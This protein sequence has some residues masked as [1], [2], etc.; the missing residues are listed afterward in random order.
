MPPVHT[1]TECNR[2]AKHVLG[3]GVSRLVSAPSRCLSF[4]SLGVNQRIRPNVTAV[5]RLQQPPQCRAINEFAFLPCGTVAVTFVEEGVGSGWYTGTH[6]PRRPCRHDHPPRNLVARAPLVPTPV[7]CTNH[8]VGVGS[9]RTNKHSALLEMLLPKHRRDRVRCGQLG[10]RA[11]GHRE[12]RAHG[13]ARG[14][15]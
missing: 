11:D 10:P 2:R 6:R 3:P 13:D 12:A 14:E 4:P 5:A 15:K 8:G 1:D 9:R 7:F